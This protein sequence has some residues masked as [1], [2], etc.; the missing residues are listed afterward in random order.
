MSKINGAFTL[1]SLMYTFSNRAANR[2][3][4]DALAPRDQEPGHQE[5]HRLHQIMEIM[6]FGNWES[7]QKIEDLHVKRA[8]RENQELKE[9]VP[10][11]EDNDNHALHIAE[12]VRY[13]IGSEKEL[14][15]VEKKRLCE[16]I[17]THRVYDRL[18]KEADKRNDN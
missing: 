6:G 14:S 16:H 3:P 12:H 4:R 17:R 11:A 10:E 7:A 5:H 1:T 9:K 2:A 15:D 8:E 18:V 13:L